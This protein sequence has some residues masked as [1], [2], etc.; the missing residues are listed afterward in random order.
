MNVEQISSRKLPQLLAKLKV[1][2]KIKSLYALKLLF[3]NLQNKF[4]SQVLINS[5]KALA[6]PVSFDHHSKEIISR[7]EL[8]LRTLV[9]VL[10][11]IY[12]SL[13]SPS[14]IVLSKELQN[15]V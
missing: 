1:L 5:L 3:E 8:H 11:Q 6:D 12:F 4:S 14:P 13:S 2:T 10:E 9:A 15:K 7:L